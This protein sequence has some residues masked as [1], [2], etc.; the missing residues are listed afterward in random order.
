ML[1]L[2]MKIKWFD[3]SYTVGVKLDSTLWFTQ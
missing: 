1:K 3:M 2:P